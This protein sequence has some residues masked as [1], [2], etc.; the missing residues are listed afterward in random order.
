MNKKQF[1]KDETETNNTD[2]YQTMIKNLYRK[3]TCRKH[4]KTNKNINNFA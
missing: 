1:F 3:N 4:V 2:N